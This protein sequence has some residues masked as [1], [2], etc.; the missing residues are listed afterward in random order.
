M[1]ACTRENSG[2][3]IEYERTS[4]L[5]RSVYTKTHES[6]Y[7]YPLYSFST[8]NKQLVTK[9]G[10]K[11]QEKKYKQ[12]LEYKETDYKSKQ[13]SRCTSYVSGT[14]FSSSER[15]W[16]F[17]SGAVERS[18]YR[19][20]KIDSSFSSVEQ[21]ELPIAE[22]VF[23]NYSLEQ[24]TVDTRHDRYEANGLSG[25]NASSTVTPWTITQSI[26]NSLYYSCY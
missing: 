21:C 24:E 14:F 2:Q 18:F 20:N 23:K 3:V 25:Q 10:S 6:S 22:G 13:Y 17:Y 1:P 15:T 12:V 4:P 19:D 9:K 16:D 8:Q 7:S 11:T 26:Y 5:F